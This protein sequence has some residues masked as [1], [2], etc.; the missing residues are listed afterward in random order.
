MKIAKRFLVAGT[1]ATI[2]IASLAGVGV[3]AQSTS[4]ESLI[5]RLAEAF[6]VSQE[7]VQTVFDEEK[8][9][10]QAELAEERSE[11]LQT[12]VDDGTITAEQKT[13]IEAKQSELQTQRESQ[14][15]ELEAWAEEND[16]DAK[17]LMGGAND[18]G[19]RG[20]FRR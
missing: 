17:Y 4:Q 5:N 20:G 15:E 14:K 2:G 19:K 10:R 16:I 18:H 11:D 7:E 3:S 1:A 8:T 13:A 12:L 9:A 6:N